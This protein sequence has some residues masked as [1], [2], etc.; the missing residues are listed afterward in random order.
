MRK[1]KLLVISSGAQHSASITREIT[2]NLKNKLQQKAILE[3]RYRDLED[4]DL[5][6]M[7]K[8]LM[9]AFF[10]SPD[11][12]TGK[13]K[14]LLVESELLIS[15]LKWADEIVIAA[16]IYNFT[17]PA[18]LKAW[19][20]LVCRAGKTFVYSEQ[21]PKGLLEVKKTYLVIA[22]GGTPIGSDIDFA[23]G[24]LE[25]IA[26]FIGLGSVEII[27]ADGSKHNRE[28]IVQNA[29]SQIVQLLAA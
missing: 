5:P 24:Y 13:Q 4:T 15:E 28:E 29:D 23:S 7:D 9:N 12:L 25:H 19:I 11:T 26:G 22:S 18:R 27:R 1:S 10:T 17:V 2:E 16:P 6:L 21:G 3:V 20:D 8:H 14:N